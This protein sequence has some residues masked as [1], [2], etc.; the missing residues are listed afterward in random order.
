MNVAEMFSREAASRPDQLA[1]I[2][3][4]GARAR[5]M[6]FRELDEESSRIAARLQ[7]SGVRHRDNVLFLHPMS[8]E[9]YATLL[10]V[11]RI[12]ACAVSVEP[13][14]PV[15]ILARLIEQTRPRAVIAGFLGLGWKWLSPALRSIPLSF[16]FG[17]NLFGATSLRGGRLPPHRAIHSVLPASPALITLTSGSEGAPKAVCRSHGFLIRQMEV[18][19]ESLDYK[20]GEVDLTTLPIFAFANLGLGLT[21]VLLPHRRASRDAA[22]VARQIRQ[23]AVSRTAAAPGFLEPLADFCLQQRTTLPSLRKIYV[24]GAPVFPRLVHKLKTVAPAAKIV[25]VY[26]ATEAEPIA[27]GRLDDLP[28]KA[29]HRVNEGFGLPAG[30]PVSAASVRIIRA[31]SPPSPQPMSHSEFSSLNLPAGKIGEIIVKGPHVLP[32]YFFPEANVAKKIRVE[33]QIWHRTGD[34]GYLDADGSIWLMGRCSAT[35]MSDRGEFY[36][37][38]VEGRLAACPDIRNA[39]LVSNGTRL[40]LFIEPSGLARNGSTLLDE[41]LEWAPIDEVRRIQRMPVDRRHQSKINYNEL[42]ELLT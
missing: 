10:A 6:T 9:L 40:V 23:C 33:G 3:G 21:T 26:G 7:S 28:D 29:W 4:E 39:A 32:E 41:F 30:L 38:Q 11:Y 20:P 31:G 18:L 13:G 15:A 16:S 12:G 8:I 24:G 17:W 25:G 2:E 1:F 36:P 22:R 37:F 42:R 35:V 34:S 19:R 5:R 14:Q 27:C